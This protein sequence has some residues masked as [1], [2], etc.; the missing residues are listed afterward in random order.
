MSMGIVRDLGPCQIDWGADNLGA[1][2]GDVKMASSENAV[3]IFEAAYG[4]TP[5]DAVFTGA[6]PVEVTVPFTRQT[7]ANLVKILPGGSLSGSSGVVVMAN[8]VGKTM[9]DLSKP[10]FIKPLVNGTAVANGYWLRVEHAYPM[11]ELDITF[12]NADQRVYN[13]RFRGFADA[14]T[15]KTWSA[16]KVNASTT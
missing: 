3:D 11:P 12:N 16:G 5:V 9:Y 8:T 14:T 7:L 2:F 1:I 4:Q 13:V 15:K 6:G 10:L